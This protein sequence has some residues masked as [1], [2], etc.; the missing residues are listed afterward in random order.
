MPS[1]IQNIQRAFAPSSGKATSHRIDASELWETRTLTAGNFAGAGAL[2]GTDTKS[3]AAALRPWSV[4]IAAGATLTTAAANQTV[5][6]ISTGTVAYWLAAGAAVPATDV[7][8]KA[9]VLTP[10]RITAQ[11]TVDKQLLMQTGDV[12]ETALR[13]DLLAA[14][15]AALDVGVFSGVGGAECIGLFFNETVPSVTLGAAPTLAKMCEIEKTL[16][17]NFAEQPGASLAWA[18]S[19][20]VRSRMRQA[21]SILGGF[22]PLWSD[23]DTVI[24][25]RAYATPGVATDQLVFGN[26]TDLEIAIFGIPE[27]LVNPFDLDTSGRVRMTA[28]VYADAAPV[29]AKSFVKTADSAAQA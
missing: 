21:P 5:P 1:L 26:F 3:P 14:I 10:R 23:A 25:K 15:G 20:A 9:T 28:T 17:D 13:R 2:I 8:A 19:P 11:L 27:L 7:S 29:R 24:G 6:Q 12:A 22:L 16:G 18:G 4:A